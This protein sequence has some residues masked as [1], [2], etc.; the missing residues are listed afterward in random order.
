MQ[1]ASPQVEDGFTRVANELLEAILRFGFTQRQL[2]VLLTVIRKTYGFGKKEDDMSASQIAAM[3]SMHRPHVATVLGELDRMNV[4]SKSPGRY[5]MLIGVNKQYSNWLPIERATKV[6]AGPAPLELVHSGSTESVHGCTESVH[7]EGVPN[8]YSTSTESVQVDSTESVHTKENLPKETQKK[9]R[10]RR[11][12]ITLVEWLAACKASG[13]MSIPKDD[14]IFDYADKQKLP[15]DFVRFAWLE[16]R[17]KYTENGK[18]QKDWRATF[19]NAVREN[20]YSL[21]FEKDG[22]FVLTTRGTQVK[23]EHEEAA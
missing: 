17:R 13:E 6:G 11:S 22:D 5:G 7:G 9:G 2:L 16:F 21:W 4:I 15:I 1:E 3:C 12:E 8:R 23:R 19:R 20:W 18:K 10:A 14:P